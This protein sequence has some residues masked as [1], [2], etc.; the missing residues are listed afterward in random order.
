MLLVPEQDPG[1]Y[2]ESCEAVDD[3]SEKR[4]HEWRRHHLE[5]QLR[6]YLRKFR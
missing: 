4:T 6:G 2:P 5:P 3:G 1:K